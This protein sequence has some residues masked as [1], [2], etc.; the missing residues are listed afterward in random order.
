M[1]ANTNPTNYLSL[2]VVLSALA[3]EVTQKV[4]STKTN[5]RFIYLFKMYF[6]FVGIGVSSACVSE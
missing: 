2:V 1:Q 4:V 3:D 5:A 6:H